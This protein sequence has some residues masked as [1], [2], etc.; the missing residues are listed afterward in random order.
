MKKI[1]ID[2]RQTN[3][4]NGSSIADRTAAVLGKDVE[5]IRQSHKNNLHT[6]AKVGILSVSTILAAPTAGNLVDNAYENNV[7]KVVN[8]MDTPA[9]QNLLD[10]WK[11]GDNPAQA[12]IE[13]PVTI[14][15][16]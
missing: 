13:I 10:G 14:D 8:D 2:S 12:T 6:A 15:K 16:P 7:T 4:A 1:N 11:T 9:Q 5:S 3:L